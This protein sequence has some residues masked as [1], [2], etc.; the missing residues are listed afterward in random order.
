MISRTLSWSRGS[1]QPEVLLHLFIYLLQGMALV[2]KN[3]AGLL[4]LLAPLFL[5]V[6]IHL[7]AGQAQRE[8]GWLHKG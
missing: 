6:L 4:I 7:S 3:N 2:L 1:R 8:Q 5:H